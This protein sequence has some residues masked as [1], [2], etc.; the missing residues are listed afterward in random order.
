MV[1]LQRRPRSQIPPSRQVSGFLYE[2]I[3]TFFRMGALAH[4]RLLGDPR[5][6][7]LFLLTQSNRGENGRW[8]AKR[9]ET[10]RRLHPNGC[11]SVHLEH[12]VC[13]GRGLLEPVFC[14]VLLLDV[15]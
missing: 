6:R 4:R 9:L 13:Q 8:F 14:T 5:E 15:L 10:V 1:R 11:E 3:V 7:K 2:N 12:A